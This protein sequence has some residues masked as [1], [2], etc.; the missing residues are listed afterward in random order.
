MADTKARWTDDPGFAEVCEHYRAEQLTLFVGAGVSAAAGLPSWGRLVE[1]LSEAARA[2][3]ASADALAEIEALAGKGKL[4]DALGALRHVLGAASFGAVVERR[5]DDRGVTDLPDVLV[6]IGALAP[7]LRAVLTT[8]LDGLLE[9]AFRG[10]WPA[11]ARA[12]ADIAQRRRCIVKLHGTLL[13]R[14]TW[15]LAREDYERAMYADPNL[16]AAYQSLFHGGRLLFVGYGLADDDFDALLGRVRALAQGQPPRHFALAPKGAVRPY[17]RQELDRAGIHVIEYGNGV[18][19][20]GEAVSFLQE[21]ARAASVPAAATPLVAAGRRGELERWERDYL[22]K[23]RVEWAGSRH[24]PLSAYAGERDL[25]RAMLYVSLYAAPQPWCR[26]LEDGRLLVKPPRTIDDKGWWSELAAAVNRAAFGRGARAPFLEEV[27]SHP[28]LPVVVLEGE[29]GSGKTALLQQVAY[30]LACRHLG[31]ALPGEHHLDLATLQQG[32]PLLR[33]PVL[34]DARRI[35]DAIEEH[36]IE[37]AVREAIAKAFSGVEAVTP[38]QVL[39]GLRHGRYLLLMDALDEVPGVAMRDRVLHALAA[40]AAKATARTDAW[41]L[42]LVLTTRPAAYTGVA[43]PR[44]L[45]ALQLASMT[46]GDAERLI[47]RWAQ[48]QGRPADERAKL[49]EAVLGVRE[50]HGIDNVLENPLLLTCLLLVYEQRK[51][52]PD[53]TA[54][55]Y[56]RMVEVLCTAKDNPTVKPEEKRQALEI[57]CRGMQE[58]GGTAWALD[59]AVEALTAWRPGLL[60][61]RDKAE[62][63]VSRLALETGLLRLEQQRTKGK[64]EVRLVRP[65][66]RSFQEY[67]AARSLAA[68]AESV[69]DKTQ[70]LF[71]ERA[72]GGARVEDP[73]WEGVLRFLVGVHGQ[74]GDANA[75][76]YV[77]TLHAAV[78]DPE[79]REGQ[80]L[81]LVASAL[82]EYA[83]CFEGHDLLT[84]LPREIVG[85][86]EARGAKWP[87]RDRVLALDALGRLPGGDPRLKGDPWVKFEAARFRMGGD[88]NAYQSAPEHEAR[89]GEFWLRRWPVTVSEYGE[90]VKAGGYGKW[91]LWDVEPEETEPWRWQ[92]QQ[93][94][95]NRSVVGVNWFEARAFCQ[96][97]NVEGRAPAGRAITLPTE[98]EWEYAARGAGKQP[99]TYAW[100]NEDPGEGDTARASYGSIFGG[101]NVPESATPVGA[102]P[103]G[104]S[105]DG[106]WDLAGTVLE[107]TACRFRDS[108]EGWRQNDTEC[109]QDDKVSSGGG[110]A[111]QRL[112]AAPRVVRGGSWYGGPGNLRAAIRLRVVPGLRDGSLGFRVVCV[113]SRQHA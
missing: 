79:R 55:L 60:T 89:V 62:D 90:F 53:S 23:K 28:D 24:G 66:H 104:H 108:K 52:L 7:K 42:R 34:L 67:L 86:F 83:E 91:E 68:G 31:E 30:I 8:N 81:G 9:R 54:A 75:R 39:D 32:A 99:R 85:A 70:G 18:G 40:E 1:L 11:V 93:R 100:G 41:P 107:W 92:A 10:E 94:H 20:H 64:A 71:V 17:R 102:Y 51:R 111:H 38:S 45:P 36:G 13:E 106:V 97:L 12:T 33:V 44:E 96:W 87:M 80:I 82:S 58:Q 105:P 84:T 76:R 47:E 15:V 59:A 46:E 6:A 14:A 63:F 29:G 69:E 113:C 110:G 3:G 49:R 4:I 57:L 25:R 74:A 37:S 21:L 109:H 65:W 43:L 5:L 22:T 95:P 112:S 72:R 19:D 16:S 27:I 77:E 98:E 50:R 101:G 61:S 26:I 103:S 48:A 78:R 73:A 56:E 35:A 88:A 2:G